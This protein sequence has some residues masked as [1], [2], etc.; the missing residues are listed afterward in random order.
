MTGGAGVQRAPEQFE[1]QDREWGDAMHGGA[2]RPRH[3]R[4]VDLP[5]LPLRCYVQRREHTAGKILLHLTSGKIPSTRQ[6]A[7]RYDD[8]SF[9]VKKLN[10]NETYKRKILLFRYHYYFLLFRVP[11]MF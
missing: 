3:L 2:A 4:Q 8:E 5:L 11:W 1:D 10:N 7:I 9:G 6:N